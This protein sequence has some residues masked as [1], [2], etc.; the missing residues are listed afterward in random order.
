M[1]PLNLTS[2]LTSVCI[3]RIRIHR[4]FVG[5]RR[6]FCIRT[7]YS[8]IVRFVA[9]GDLLQVVFAHVEDLGVFRFD[10]GIFLVD[11]A[12]DFLLVVVRDLL[13]VLVPVPLVV[14]V[15]VFVKADG[16]VFLLERFVSELHSRRLD[17]FVVANHRGQ[18]VLLL[19]VCFAHLLLLIQ[20]VRVSLFNMRIGR[21]AVPETCGVDFV[22]DGDALG[23]VCPPIHRLAFLAF[24]L[25]RNVVLRVFLVVIVSVSVSGVGRMHRVV[26]GRLGGG[27]VR[28]VGL[29][30]VFVSL[31]TV[32]VPVRLLRLLR[33]VGLVGI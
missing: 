4:N 10:C 22:V 29:T 17:A 27:L 18:L 26:R 2:T 3:L 15:E 31:D 30:L 24:L 12:L 16:G 19:F 5:R 9:A 20:F 28:L 32:R 33:P 14:A 25:G 21:G 6:H 1:L 8:H 13:V 11:H 7:R 23:A